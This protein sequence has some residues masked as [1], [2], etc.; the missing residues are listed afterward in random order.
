[1][2][3]KKTLTDIGLI[4]TSYFLLLSNVVDSLC[5]R[6]SKSLHIKVDGFIP[7]VVETNMCLEI[8]T[9]AIVPE[10]SYGVGYERFKRQY[11]DNCCCQIN[12]S[13]QQVTL[14]SKDRKKFRVAKYKRIESCE[15]KYCDKRT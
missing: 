14:I 6:Q 3:L 13:R 15:C 12:T 1:M 7:R 10:V 8:V 5:M 4:L 2:N 11:T 9:S